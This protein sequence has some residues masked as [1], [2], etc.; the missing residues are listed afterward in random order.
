VPR[1]AASDAE[2]VLELEADYEASLVDAVAAFA[3]TTSPT[4]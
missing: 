1:P 3:R 2:A 4:H